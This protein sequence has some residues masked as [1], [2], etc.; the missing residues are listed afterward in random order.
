LGRGVAGEFQP[1]SGRVAI[2]WQKDLNTTAHEIGHAIDDA[3]GL[4]GPEAHSHWGSL[5]NELSD[6]WEFGSDPPPTHDNPEQYRMME[7]MAEFIRAWMVNP[8]ETQSRYPFTYEW[9]QGRVSQDPGVWEGLKQFS[10]DIREFWGAEI[11]DQLLSTIMLKPPKVTSMPKV[12]VNSILRRELRTGETEHGQFILTPWD[13]W[14]Q[15][16]TNMFRPLERVWRWAMNE[17]GLDLND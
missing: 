3:F 7:G 6:L 16:Y 13:N 14:A 10:Q 9:F 8:D 4:L 12:V 5:R 15:K 2:K 1:G 11:G 17:Q